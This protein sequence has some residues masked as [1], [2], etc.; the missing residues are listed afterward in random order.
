MTKMSGAFVHGQWAHFLASMEGPMK[1]VVCLLHGAT[2][3]SNLTSRVAE[4]DLINPTPTLTPT[5]CILK[6][7]D[8]DSDSRNFF[9][10]RLPTPTPD[11]DY[12]KHIVI[13]SKT[14]T[15]RFFYL[16]VLSTYLICKWQLGNPRLL[17]L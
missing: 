2:F 17:I 13:N 12:Q 11:S 10:V 3:L 7:Y 5:P 8:S 1:L 15:H 4:S 14:C 9:E 6:N 16:T